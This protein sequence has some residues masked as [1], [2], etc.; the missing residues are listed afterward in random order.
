MKLNL[1][2]T[3]K[4]VD[5]IHELPEAWSVLDY[6]NLLELADF[7]DGDN[8]DES[9][10]KDYLIMTLQDLEPDDAATIVLNYRLGEK[11]TKG[12]IQNMAQEMMDENLWEEYKDIA[13]HKD[14]FDC[15]VLL[16]WAFP[17]AFPETDALRCT[18]EI[19]NKSKTQLS[20][21]QLDKVM[22][23]RLLSHGMDDHSIINRLFDEQIKEGSFEEANAIIWAF[24][25]LKE[26]E[27]MEVEVYSSNYWLDDLDSI[28]HFDVLMA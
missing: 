24:K 11:L 6:R 12:Q 25:I 15:A 18:I 16:K 23:T 27:K 5:E 28:S 2:V 3:V 26:G 22:L 19:E 14:L 7:D 17:R 9:E 20:G 4:R 8:I 10:L 13:L 1:G 21:Q